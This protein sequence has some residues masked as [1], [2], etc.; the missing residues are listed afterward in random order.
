V[1]GDEKRISKFGIIYE[2]RNPK[3]SS[4]RG[5]QK[6]AVHPENQMKPTKGP[7]G[8]YAELLDVIVGLTTVTVV[9]HSKCF[10]KSAQ[11]GRT[12]HY[13]TTR[14]LQGYK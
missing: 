8:R 4:C 2:I 14:E 9:L 1:R 10:Q 7:Y 5:L 12:H 6:L 13:L 3:F 11:Q